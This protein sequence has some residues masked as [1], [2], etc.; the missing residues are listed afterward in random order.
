MF[1]DKNVF[2]NPAAYTYGTSPRSMVDKLRNVNSFNESM[3]L[4]REFRL[5]ES[6]SLVVQ[7]DVSNPTNFV[8]FGNPSTSFT[9]TSWGTITSQG[10]GPR[11]VQLSARV[12]F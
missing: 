6:K 5:M 9:S 2:L 4:K 3:S 10:N 7:A 8:I 12:K 1:L 11:Y